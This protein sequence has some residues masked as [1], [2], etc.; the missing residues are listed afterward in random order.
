MR[1]IRGK[2]R[3]NRGMIVGFRHGC[4]T[5]VGM[6]ES[7]YRV[8]CAC[9]RRLLI[10]QYRMNPDRHAPHEICNETCALKTAS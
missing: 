7:A 8:E 5:V 1:R 4:L 10:S 9:G 3:N 2:G 6:K